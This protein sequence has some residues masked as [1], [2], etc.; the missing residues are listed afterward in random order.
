MKDIWV[1]KNAC[2]KQGTQYFGLEFPMTLERLWRNVEFV[3]PS[4]RAANP[5]GNVSDVP[6]HAWHT[7]GTD[8]FYWNKIDYLV[9]WRLLL[10]VPD[11]EKTSQ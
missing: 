3:K 8:L 6:P 9:I 10:Q 2:S 1:L 4:S 11:C 7:L 5:V